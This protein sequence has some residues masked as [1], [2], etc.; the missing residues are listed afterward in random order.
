M[1]YT[2]TN[3]NR[4]HFNPDKDECIDIDLTETDTEIP[5]VVDDEL[6]DCWLTPDALNILNDLD[7]RRR[8]EELLISLS[9]IAG[10]VVVIA[11]VIVYAIWRYI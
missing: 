9:V 10:C 8:R 3:M 1:S 4:Q 2:R 7:R 5:A 6:D 11:L